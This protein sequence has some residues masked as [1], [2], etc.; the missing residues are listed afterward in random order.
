MSAIDAKILKL[1]ENVSLGY[2]GERIVA[3]LE[4]AAKLS[5]VNQDR[6]DSVIME[7]ADFVKERVDEENALTRNTSLEAERML[8]ELSRAAKA[9]TVLCAAHAHID[10]NWMWGWDET[11]AVTLDTVR[12]MLDL[13]DEYPDFKFSQSQAAVYKLIA[14]YAP[15]MLEDVKKR[16]R[17]GRWEVTA[18]HWVE[19]DKNMPNG[20]SLSRHI[21]YT[22]NYL[23]KLLDIPP[24]SLNLDFEP[25]TFGHSL[26]VPEILANGGVKYY[27]HC[28]GYDGHNLYRWTGPSGKSVL[29]YREPHW[30]NDQ[31]NAKMAL[32]V[33]EF[34]SAHHMDTM[35]R[36][37]GV[38]DHGGGPTRRDL[39]R[40]IDM[41]TW[42]V[43]P[44]F[45]FGAFAEFYQL[46]EKVADKLP[47]VEGELNFVFTGCYTS[48]SRIKMANRI[49]EAALNEAEAFGAISA[50]N[51]NYRY[52]GE[53]LSK[54]WQNI[55]FNQFHDIIPGSGVIETRE[56]AM[57][58]FQNAMAA[59]N[60]TR[61]QAMRSIAAKIN[62]SGLIAR[63]ENKNETVSE[64]AGV[65][66]RAASFKISHVE[67]GSG[68]TRIFHLFNSS[69]SERSEAADLTIWDWTGNKDHI[70]FRDASG[71][72]I[73]HQLL[74]KGFNHYWGHHYMRVLIRANVPAFG[75]TTYTM[76]EEDVRIPTPIRNQPRVE[77]LKEYV[78][79]NNLME[80][81][82]DSND[83]SITAMIDKSTGENLADQSRRAGIFRFIEEDADRGMTAWI[84]GRYMNV[85]DLIHNV[86][87]KKADYK[88]TDIRQSLAYEIQFKSSTLKATVSLDHDSPRLDFDVECDWHE[89]GRKH[90]SIPQL[91]F[92]LPLSYTCHTY[93]YDVPFGTIERKPMEM[94]VP[95]NS[96]SLAVR[97]QPGKKSAMLATDSKYG[98]RGFDNALGITLIR[99]SFD[100]DPYPE[101]GVHK[102]K[103]AICLVN[104][105]SNNEAI[106]TAYRF[107]HPLNA[108][109]DHAHPGTLPTSKSFISLVEG[110]V[111]VS[112]IKMAED[113]S[114]RNAIIVRVYETEGIDTTAVLRFETIPK[115]ASFVDINENPIATGK[116]I[117]IEANQLIFD[118]S[119]SSLATIYVELA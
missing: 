67:R 85:T 114:K 6:F 119:A 61:S 111:A 9:Y 73:A 15:G 32:Y 112:S 70:V 43:F 37:Y 78:L 44:Q 60:S 66:F 105:A 21:L 69:A 41:N 86:K 45:K 36:V 22:K 92:F 31:I 65:G 11:V 48:Q 24:E 117:H 8:Q 64:G 75:Y 109:S 101:I 107:N 23:S 62:T 10:M 52:P 95:G 19:A 3:Q 83:G 88:S 77:R 46:A 49:G 56:H 2:W 104:D 87:I 40:I 80:V 55:L 50:V 116:K 81:R 30:Y 84:V 115:R 38:G 26:Q 14:E 96:W 76:T 94:D 35:L 93:K 106:E 110:G 57:G 54:A 16:V 74:D 102:F 39:E 82:F 29:V 103:L 25:D 28:R 68:T 5:K 34:C 98:F 118:V 27:Y 89:I 53:L 99:S 58:L 63:Q 97:H 42:P 79:E 47:E 91:N 90:Q 72:R 51:T 4:Y 7:A 113:P 13:L 18:S 1:S 59:A 20:E 108:L 17:E 100:P 12:T 71:A 33:P